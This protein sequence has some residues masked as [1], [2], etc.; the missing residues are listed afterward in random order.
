MMKN[1][2]F[3]YHILLEYA[4]FT[5]TKFHDKMYKTERI[6]V[7]KTEREAIYEK[8][9][10]KMCFCNDDYEYHHTSNTSTFICC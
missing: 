2:L 9:Y 8:K 1:I 10:T 5:K 4:V 7:V 6:G 3:F